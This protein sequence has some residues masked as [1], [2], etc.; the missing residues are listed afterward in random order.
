MNKISFPIPIPI[1]IELTNTNTNTNTIESNP[2]EQTNVKPKNNI[3]DYI[4]LAPNVFMFC[5]IV[6]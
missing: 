1:P 2:L 3:T 4:K 5:N 6:I